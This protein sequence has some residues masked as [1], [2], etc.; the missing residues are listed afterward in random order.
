MQHYS[1]SAK[2]ARISQ[3]QYRKY[4]YYLSGG[5]ERVGELLSETLDM[6]QTYI[7][8]DP[9]RK[10][11]FDG[12]L[13]TPTAVSIGL[14]TDYSSL[15]ASWLLE[16]ERRGPRAAE[17]FHKIN[18]TTSGIAAL[19]NGFVSGSAMY[20]PQTGALSPP[21]ADPTNNGTVAVSHLN[22][23]F[24][25]PE[26]IADLTAHW[27]GGGAEDS[28]P[29]GFATAWLEYCY[30]YGANATEQAARYGEAFSGVALQM[31]HSRL[32][33]YAAVTR[34]KDEGQLAARAWQ[35]FETDMT[36]GAL[37]PNATWSRAILNGSVV[38]APVE[39]AAFIVTTNAVAQYGLAAIQNLA[40]VGEYL[41]S[42]G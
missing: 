3:P 42:Y 8:L 31:A 2:Q 30:Y 36:T 21:Y 4:F 35:E 19:K 5:D 32:A 18:A 38:L 22:A 40:Y 6:D 16:W 23:V 17:A 1:D 25:L 29:P 13:P 39:E 24:G 33:A 20:N 15:L 10:D 28:M 34:G 9:N 41:T 11:R 14:G 27:G 7:T 26:A 12:Y 37:Q